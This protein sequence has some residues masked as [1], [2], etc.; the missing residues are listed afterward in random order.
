[1]IVL[2]FN[3]WQI[4]NDNISL[5]IQ[6]CHQKQEAHVLTSPAQGGLEAWEGREVQ[7]LKFFP[8]V[9]SLREITVISRQ[10]EVSYAVA[11]NSLWAAFPIDKTCII[12]ALKITYTVVQSICL[13]TSVE[14]FIQPPLPQHTHTH[15]HVRTHTDTPTSFNLKLL[16]Q[17]PAHAR[18]FLFFFFNKWVKHVTLGS[19]MYLKAYY[20]VW[21]IQSLHLFW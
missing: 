13:Q 5:R 16:K 10:S 12:Q 15:A 1:M 11:T 4:N 9:S 20:I 19:F 2:S 6:L 7:T 18:Q 21:R 17:H 3:Y 14:S 8:W